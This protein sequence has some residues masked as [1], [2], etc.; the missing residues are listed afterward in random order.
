M[1]ANEKEGI[2][3]KQPKTHTARQTVAG[4]CCAAMKLSMPCVV[5]DIDN[6]VD[7]AYAGWPERIFVI[8]AEDRVAYAGH[9]GPWG[10]KPAEVEGWLRKNIGPPSR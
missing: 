7:D 5:D 4:R 10:F 2:V 6:K 1:P 9:Q 3:F 8:D